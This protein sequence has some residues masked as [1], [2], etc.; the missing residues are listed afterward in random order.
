MVKSFLWCGVGDAG[1]EECSGESNL[2]MDVHAW[3][4]SV[5]VRELGLILSHSEAF[6]VG[7]LHGNDEEF[8]IDFVE[9]LCI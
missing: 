8:V 9:N 3:L 1:L 4:L 7:C 5:W 2:V 6:L